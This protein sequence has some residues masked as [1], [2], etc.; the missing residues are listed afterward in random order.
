MSEK[1]YLYRLFDDKL[2]FYLRSVG[3][4]L[5]TGPKFC[6]KSTTASRYAKTSIDLTKSATRDYYISLAKVSPDHFL[7]LGEKPMLIDEWQVISFIWNDIKASLCESGAF[8]QYILTG[9][10]TDNTKAIA[11]AAR[12]T[13]TGR[14]LTL[15]MRTLSLFESGDSNGAVS[16]SKLKNGVFTP[17]QSKKTIDDYAFLICRGGWP[18]S[19]GQEEDVALQQSITFTEGTINEDFFSLA[20]VPLRKDVGKSR[21]FLRSYARHIGSQA[22]DEEIR[23]DMAEGIDD[24]TFKKYLLAL[25]R[26][27]ISDELEAW[28]PNLRSKTAIRTKNTRYFVDPSIATSVL[29]VGPSDLFRDMR[30]FGFLFESLAVRDL[31]VYCSAIDAHLFHYRDK[32]GREVDAVIQF[33]DGDWALIEVKMGDFE[34]IEIAAKKLIDLSKDVLEEKEKPAF[35]MIITKDGLAYQRDDGVFVVPLACLRE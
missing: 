2:Q 17:S 14:I 7:N 33:K 31:K 19:I 32:L 28:N 12:H 30:T 27:Y 10:V 4:V 11:P 13:G 16:I 25:E 18:L 3:A 34:D 21:K 24:E 20:D 26:L 29:G 6:G 8:G 23:A 5:I 15:V 22:G 35:L 9:S 1:K